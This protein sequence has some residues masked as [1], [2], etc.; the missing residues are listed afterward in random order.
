MAVASGSNIHRQLQQLINPAEGE[1]GTGNTAN[2]RS[3]KVPKTPDRVS[4]VVFALQ[5]LD[6]LLLGLGLP[7]ATAAGE[8]GERRGTERWLESVAV[9]R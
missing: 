4:G 5:L 9:Y 2:V 6:F 7:A 8:S 1:R 3:L